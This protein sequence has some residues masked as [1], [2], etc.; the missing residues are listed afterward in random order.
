MF[1]SIKFI[2][3]YEFPD[4]W[5]YRFFTSPKSRS[6]P[7][8]CSYWD[9]L[10]ILSV[11]GIIELIHKFIFVTNRL[12]HIYFLLN[13]I[14]ISI[15]SP[16]I[17]WISVLGSNHS[18]IKFCR[19]YLECTLLNFFKLHQI[20]RLLMWVYLYYISYKK[21]ALINLNNNRLFIFINSSSLLLVFFKISCAYI[22]WKL[23][24]I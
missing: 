18:L 24:P 15:S 2:P 3:P 13:F 7:H 6:Q 4:I 12:M 19:V 23:V 20:P 22:S 17:T 9:I 10:N 8:F 5:W 21:I 14:Y 1:L 16:A 11:Y